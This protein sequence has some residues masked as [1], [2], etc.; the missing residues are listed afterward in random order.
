MMLF[1][2]YSDLMFARVSALL[3]LAAVLV[4]TAAAQSLP[5]MSGGRIS[6]TDGQADLHKC[7]EID[8]LS[9]VSIEDLYAGL[10]GAGADF[11]L[12]ND[13]RGWTDPLTER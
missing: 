9:R 8:M 3:F 5:T 4:A 12:L 7:H 2:Q 10:P 13:I 11:K 6:R 1:C